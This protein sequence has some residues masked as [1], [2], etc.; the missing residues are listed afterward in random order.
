MLT[1]SCEVGKDCYSFF[2]N[3]EMKCTDRGIVL[4][5]DLSAYCWIQ[6]PTGAYRQV[7]VQY[8]HFQSFCFPVPYLHVHINLNSHDSKV[9]QDLLQGMSK[10]TFFLMGIV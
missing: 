9:S 1:T 8:L 5:K 2:I 4:P 3:G 10:S 7:Y 6:E